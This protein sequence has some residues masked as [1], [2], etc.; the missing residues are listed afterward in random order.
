MFANPHCAKNEEN[1]WMIKNSFVPIS[2]STN[3]L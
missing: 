1:R 3:W 2:E